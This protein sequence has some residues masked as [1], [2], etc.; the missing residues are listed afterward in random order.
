MATFTFS[1]LGRGWTIGSL[2][3]DMADFQADLFH[4]VKV[5]FNGEP[6]DWSFK[7][8]SPRTVIRTFDLSL[9]VIDS[10]NSTGELTVTINRAGSTDFYGFDYVKL[11]DVP[12]SVPIPAAF[13]LFGSAM[14]GMGSF[15]RRK[16]V[17]SA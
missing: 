5:D 10:I 7:D 11:S 17:P 13:W 4:P 8:F 2:E 1:G 12:A 15:V 6:Q 14:V 9:A 16:Q 3:F